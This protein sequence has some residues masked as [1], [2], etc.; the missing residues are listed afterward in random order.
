MTNSIMTRVVKA[1]TAAYQ[2]LP[3]DST[4]F[5]TTRGAGGSVTFTL[6]ASTDIPAGWWAEFATCAAQTLVI[7]SSPVDTLI[8]HADLTADTLTSAATIGQHFKVIYDGTGFFVQSD[9]S[10]A[11]TATA[12][13]AVTLAT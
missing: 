10:V 7:A 4:V 3:T 9:S 6:P 11:T 1:K 8:V 2:C 5:F 12:V 13:T